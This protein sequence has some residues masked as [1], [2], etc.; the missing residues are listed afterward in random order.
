MAHRQ[1]SCENK[2]RWREVARAQSALRYK[3]SEEKSMSHSLAAVE[4][5]EISGSRGSALCRLA[6]PSLRRS[7]RN[8]RLSSEQEEG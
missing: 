7:Q 5:S 4:R 8:G 3:F 1:R 2:S 6:L